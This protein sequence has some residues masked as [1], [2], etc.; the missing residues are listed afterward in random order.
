M[1]KKK[2]EQSVQIKLQTRAKAQY[3]A[4]LLIEKP[5]TQFHKRKTNE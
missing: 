5:A 4:F 1:L 3:L 2:I